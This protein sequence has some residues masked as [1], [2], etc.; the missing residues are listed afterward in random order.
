MAHTIYETTPYLTAYVVAAE[1]VDTA[2]TKFGW[3]ESTKVSKFGDLCQGCL[4]RYWENATNELFPE[5][6]VPDAPGTYNRVF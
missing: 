2:A 5:G 6:I 1:P 3:P 4:E